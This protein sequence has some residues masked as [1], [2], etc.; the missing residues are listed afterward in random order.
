MR[1]PR[2]IGDPRL[3]ELLSAVLSVAGD[4][5]LPTVLRRIAESARSLLGARYCALGVLGDDGVLSEFVPIGLDEDEVAAIGHTPEGLGI[6]GL[7]VREPLPLR[8]ERLQDHPES[9]GF[10]PAH[11]PMT[12]FLGVPIV[13]RG[14]A[15]GNL[16]LCDKE[17]GSSFSAEDENLA[18]TLA[19]AAAIAV[20]NAR[21]H[22]RVQNI[23]VLSE[24]ER[25]ARDLH[26]TVI[27]QLFAIGM[28]LQAASRAI[29]DPAA[30]AR[31]DESV[32][33]LDNTVREIRTTIFGLE[34]EALPGR[35]VR[36]EMLRVVDEMTPGLR[37][38]P[39]VSFD[40]PVDVVTPDAVAD[41]LV[42]TLREALANVARHADATR[43]EVALR[44][45]D[46]IELVVRDDGC[47]P[48][49]PGPPEGRG[50]GLNNLRQRAEAHGGRLDVRERT[51]GGTELTWE[52]PVG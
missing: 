42:A 7:L 31:V 20:E 52:V 13:V 2:V 46:V 37:T 19:A 5:E 39:Q 33:R 36:S 14:E 11:P 1:P 45:D 48:S 18:V 22:T 4:L 30:R 40:G 32:D 6:L 51:D 27:Q 29:D 9:V 34:T 43:V 21:L 24:R 25:I 10:P 16:Y 28:A 38:R 49:G 15:Y 26:D 47:G 50:H 35:Q 3:D 23:A 17:D 8:L 12:S 41:D 44:A